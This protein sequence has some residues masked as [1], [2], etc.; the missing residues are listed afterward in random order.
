LNVLNIHKRVIDLPKSDF[1]EPLKSLSTRSDQIWPTEYWPRM[2][3][4]DGISNGAQGGH[5]PIRYL[6]THYEPYNKIAF[7]FTKP[8]G[9]N[10]FHMLE[11]NALSSQ[12]TELK[13]TID[14]ETRG[15]ETFLW[16]VAVRWLHDALIE[17]AFDKLENGLLGTLKTTKWGLW[18]R[19][20]RK[21]FA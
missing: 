1:I 2:V 19:L 8:Q 20:L 13:H 11:I 6:V 21:L 16:L 17:D 7:R 10:G 18:V 14:M 12:K 9:F 4:K 5:G 3:F 15:K